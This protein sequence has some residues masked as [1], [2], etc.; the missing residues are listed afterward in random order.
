MPV[1]FRQEIDFSTSPTICRFFE[2][3]NPVRLIIGPVGSGATTACCTEIM[4]RALEQEPSPHDGIRRFK[5]LVVRNTVPELKRT[6]IETWLS[7]FPEQA[8]GP[9][10]GSAPVQHVIQI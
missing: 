8:C 9:M 2:D 5:A 10:R 4:R 1:A 7:V 3:H 6:T